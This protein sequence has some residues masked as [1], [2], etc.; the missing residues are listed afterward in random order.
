MELAS[1][2]CTTELGTDVW[3]VRVFWQPASGV[4]CPEFTTYVVRG[5]SQAI[6]AAVSVLMSCSHRWALVKAS[7]AQIRRTGDLG[8]WRP[9]AVTRSYL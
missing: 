1:T 4:T 5:E 6:D 9:V 7:G 8:R 3:D 2:P